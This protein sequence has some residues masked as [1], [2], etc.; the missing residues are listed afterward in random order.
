MS[1]VLVSV[2]CITYNHEDYIA[3]AIEGFLMQKTDFEYEILIHDDASTD[4]TAEIIREYEKKYPDL[5]KPI[6]QTENQFSKG[7]SRISYTFND[8]RV[9]GEY[10]A[11]CEGDDY[12]TDPKKLQKQVDYM[13]EH[14]DCS[15]T[16]HAAEILY[17]GNK[18]LKK[19]IKPY[20]SDT[21]VSIKD[22]II[23]GGGHCPTASILYKKKI[24]KD[25][26][27]LFFEWPVGDYILQ[28]LLADNGFVYYF[29]SIMSVYRKGI[30]DSWTNRMRNNPKKRKQKL[31]LIFDLFNKLDEITNKN[32]TNYI[33][34]KK[35]IDRGTLLLHM[36]RFPEIM[37][38]KY[39]KKHIKEIETKKR[40]KI[41]LLYKF[42]S[43]YNILRNIKHKII[44]K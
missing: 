15:M 35:L 4:G 22:I 32:Y 20:D 27:D 9:E 2:N 17:E 3:D 29:D 34:K 39:F 33:K 7:V 23:E 19:K 16:F 18:G 41:F 42:P 12:W 8:T 11:L 30:N 21:R 36:A 24:L 31:E 10:I 38:K 6:Y 5:I 43:L 28:I 26:P 1:D 40:F 13:E 14:P 44:K 37:D 25:P